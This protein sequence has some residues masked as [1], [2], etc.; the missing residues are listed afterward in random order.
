MNELERKFHQDMIEIYHL[1]KKECNY[2]PTRFLQLVSK[3]GGVDAAKQLI[4]KPSGTEGFSTLWGLGRLD[5]SV[6]AFVLKPE[7]QELFSLED[8][9]LCKKRLNEY[10]YI[11]D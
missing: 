1:S 4:R 10:G 9:L 5:L 8:R 6:E 7:Y 11:I 2:T 3:I